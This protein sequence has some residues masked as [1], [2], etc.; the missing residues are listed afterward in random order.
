MLLRALVGRDP[1]TVAARKAG[2]VLRCSAARQRGAMP[3]DPDLRKKAQGWAGAPRLLRPDGSFGA[4]DPEE[5][6][7]EPCHSALG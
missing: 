6:V 1:A 2:F 3:N 5:R 7:V 4:R